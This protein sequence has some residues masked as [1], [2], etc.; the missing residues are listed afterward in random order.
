MKVRVKSREEILK[1]LKDLGVKGVDEDGDF[2]CDCGCF[3]NR[4]FYY[5]GKFLHVSE[6]IHTDYEYSCSNHYWKKEWLDFD[7]IEKEDDYHKYKFDEGKTRW[8]LI[9]IECFEAITANK[10][11]FWANA[12]L[13]LIEKHGIDLIE[14]LAEVRKVLEYGADEKYGFDPWKKLENAQQR[15]FASHMRHTYDDDGE[16]FETCH[17][18]ESGFLSVYHSL[19]N[20]IFLLYF[21]IHGKKGLDKV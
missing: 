16:F 21:E 11:Y 14:S 7:V 5:C 8:D 1:L 3:F 20:C 13:G 10:N 17:K 18:D 9:P 4:M 15:Y 12:Y 19:S 2:C 6:D